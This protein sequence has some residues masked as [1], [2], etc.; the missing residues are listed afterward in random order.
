[1]FSVFV[2]DYSS[3]VPLKREGESTNTRFSTSGLFVE[4]LSVNSYLHKYHE[5][6]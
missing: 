6:L 2:L 1:M 4:Y 3:I 5:M